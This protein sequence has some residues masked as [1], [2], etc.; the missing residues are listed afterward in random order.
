MTHSRESFTPKYKGRCGDWFDTYTYCKT[1]ETAA[2]KKLGH[3]ENVKQVLER[4]GQVTFVSVSSL[5]VD[6]QKHNRK[7]LERQK[8]HF[9]RV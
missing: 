8:H 9:T 2:R 4:E 7:F 5:S 1:T 3:F 6:I